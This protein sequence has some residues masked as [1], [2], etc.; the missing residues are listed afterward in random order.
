MI[1]LSM[2]LA[3]KRHLSDIGRQDD[4][5]DEPQQVPYC[6][7]TR[8]QLHAYALLNNSFA[9]ALHWNG[10]S[11]GKGR[12]TTMALISSTAWKLRRWKTTPPG[13]MAQ[14]RRMQQAMGRRPRVRRRRRRVPPPRR[15]ARVRSASSTRRL[16]TRTATG[17]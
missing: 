17:C 15:R 5:T 16:R 4:D 11:S 10:N 3:P 6:M 1:L 7:Q 9:F 14:R 12:R 8:T 2:L 13:L